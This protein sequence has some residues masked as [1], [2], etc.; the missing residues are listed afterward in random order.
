MNRLLWLAATTLLLAGCTIRLGGPMP[1]EYRTV[2]WQIPTGTDAADA[3]AL[4]VAERARVALLLA[5]ADTAWFY[6]VAGASGRSVSGPARIGQAKIA[7]LGDGEPVGDTTVALPVDG[8]G[9]II[10]HDALYEVDDYRYLNLL[11]VHFGRDLDVRESVRTLLRYIA[12]DVM[13]AST[14][15][16]AVSTPDVATGDEV[17]ALLHPHLRDAAECDERAAPGDSSDGLVRLFFGPEARAHCADARR[18]S[19]PNAPVLM[20]VVVQR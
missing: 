14:V 5:D 8:G 16:L 4:L 9:E 20:R 19:A 3:A 18:L 7:F 13:I 15:V 12:T 17:A 1:V 2:G 11:A 6:Q 10:V